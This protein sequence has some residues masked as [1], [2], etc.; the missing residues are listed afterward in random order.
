VTPREVIRAI[1]ADGWQEVAAVGS[2]RQFRHPTKPGKV[3]VPM[4]ARDLKP[5]TLRSVE[6]QSGLRLGP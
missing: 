3:T 1:R 6:R 4:H 5:R 2:H